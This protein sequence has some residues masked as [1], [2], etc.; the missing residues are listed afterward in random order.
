[1]KKG[2]AQTY[3]L[4]E[5]N[6]LMQTNPKLLESIQE[7]A[8][9]DAMNIEDVQKQQLTVNEAMEAHT[10]SINNIL[11]KAAA[12]GA[13]GGQARDFAAALAD[14]D[15]GAEDIA[16]K[17]IGAS[18]LVSSEIGGPEGAANLLDQQSQTTRGL[19]NANVMQPNDFLLEPGKSLQTAAAGEVLNLIEPAANDTI[20]G[21]TDILNSISN[22][23]NAIS[24][25]TTTNMGG[26]G[27]PGEVKLTG[28]LELKLDGRSMNVSADDIFRA[29]SPPSYERLA[30]E[31]SNTVY[32]T[33]S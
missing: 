16:N 2:Q 30:L 27:G 6:D 4:E 3:L 11:I 7:Q 28:T 8:N 31:L 20:L 21:G 23:Q 13:F 15:F 18:Q 24:N 26:G 25:M 1:M 32:G 22:T 14:V 33:S 10:A 29:L 9:K 17:L 12:D 5:L 19:L